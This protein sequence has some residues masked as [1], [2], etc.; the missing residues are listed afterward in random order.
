MNRGS[1]E[2]AIDKIRRHQAA[3]SHR[4][5]GDGAAASVASETAP[6][7]HGVTGQ[8]GLEEADRRPVR[9]DNDPLRWRRGHL[10]EKGQ[11]PVP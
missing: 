7:L 4:I 10:P 2:M 1:S 6:V 8:H 9:D 5:A 11:N 3:V